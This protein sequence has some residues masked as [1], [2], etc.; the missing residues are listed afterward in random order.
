MDFIS[1]VPCP[2]D[3]PL[4]LTHN[5]N[6]HLQLSLMD[7]YQSSE[8][9][10]RRLQHKSPPPQCGRP[11]VLI[12]QERPNTLPPRTTTTNDNNPYTTSRC[13]R[14]HMPSAK[15]VPKP[16]T[17]WPPPNLRHGAAQEDAHHSDGLTKSWKIHRCPWVMPWQHRMTDHSG[18][19]SFVVLRVLRRKQTKQVRKHQP[20]SYNLH[21]Q[22]W[23]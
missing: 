18:D 8:E 10:P 13:L 5:V 1:P 14:T 16:S 9:T 6:T 23:H 17:C 11:L 15:P 7:T 22:D 4:Q 12:R 2:K 3:A 20:I 21:S 19:R